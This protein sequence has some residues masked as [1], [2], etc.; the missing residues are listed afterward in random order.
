MVL[1]PSK[2]PYHC[3][4]LRR[5]YLFVSQRGTIPFVFIGE[6]LPFCVHT[7]DPTFCVH[8]MEHKGFGSGSAI[9]TLHWGR[10][11]FMNDHLRTSYLVSFI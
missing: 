6:T 8:M 2:G 3:V 1:G 5:H 7:R 11:N 10:E 4:H 9:I